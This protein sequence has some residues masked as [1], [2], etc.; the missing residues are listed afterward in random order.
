MPL[1][2]GIEVV[3]E[4]RD[5]YERMNLK[6]SSNQ[7]ELQQPEYVFLTAFKTPHFM[8]YLKTFGLEKCYEKPIELEDL[9]Q[10]LESVSVP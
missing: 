10:I 1:K 6:E 3:K 9:L 8:G 4:I 2:N 5:F 7:I